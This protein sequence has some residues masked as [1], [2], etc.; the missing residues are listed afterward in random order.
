M[1]TFGLGG[2][3]RAA[4][5]AL[6]PAIAVGGAMALPVALCLFGALSLQPS[7][8]K[9]AASARPI[10]LLLLLLFVGWA[11]LSWAWTTYPQTEQPP[12]LAILVPL[13]LMFA[14]AAAATPA[15]RNAAL[16]GGLAAAIVMMALLAVEALWALPFNRAAQPDA[17]IGQLLQNTSRATTILLAICWVGAAWL[18]S[19]GGAARVGAARILLVA[20][21]LLALQTDQI[22]S[23]VAWGFGL[24][25]FVLAFAAPRFAILATTTGLAIWMLA[26]PFLTPLLLANQRLVDALPDSWAIRAGMWEY[27][28]AKIWE[29]PWIGHGIDASRAVAERLQVREF[30]FRAVQLHPHSASLQIWYELGFVGAALAALTLLLG[31]WSLARLFAHNRAGAAAAA[32]TIAA[33]GLI[34]NVSYGVWQEWWNATMLVAAALVAAL[35]VRDAKA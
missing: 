16:A 34:A 18:I 12:K 26:A 35:A 6:L 8:L 24:A 25:A 9:Q 10:A 32:A 29:S 31:G 17:E 7:V 22:A 30:E 21:A 5:F 1:K 23:I 19:I 20:C 3:A 11:C 4:F 33:L 13:G 14:G 2:F 28:C 27:V 15:A